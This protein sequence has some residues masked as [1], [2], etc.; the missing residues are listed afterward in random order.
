M[1]Q[2][3]RNNGNTAKAIQVNDTVTHPLAEAVNDRSR[4][5]Y[6]FLRITRTP[7]PGRPDSGRILV[8]N[9]ASGE[10]TEHY[11]LLFNVRFKEE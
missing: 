2:L 10:R 11:A 1:A 4:F 3:V 7:L 8:E 9:V 5:R 6:K